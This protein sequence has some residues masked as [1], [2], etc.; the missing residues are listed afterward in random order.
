M[1]KTHKTIFIIILIIAVISISLGV[2]HTIYLS[3][4]GKEDPIDATKKESFEDCVSQCGTKILQSNQYLNYATEDGRYFIS[5]NLLKDTFQ[6]D[7]SN[8]L[9]YK[10]KWSYCDLDK[11]GIYIIPNSDFPIS[12]AVNDCSYPDPGKK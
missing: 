4:K 11:S 7:F 5:I 2:A 12:I 1:K 10:E 6:C 9:D 3:K 8:C